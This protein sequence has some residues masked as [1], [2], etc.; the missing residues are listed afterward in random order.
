MFSGAPVSEPS[1]DINGT[2]GGD[3]TGRDKTVIQ[4]AGGD[5]VGRDKITQAAPPIGVAALHQLPAPPS[6][7]VGRKRELRDLAQA[8]QARGLAIS[9]LRGMGRVG[10]TALA[11]KLAERLMPQFPDA[12]FSYDWTAPA[13]RRLTRSKPWRASSALT[14]PRRNC[15]KNWIAGGRSTYRF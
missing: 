2:V 15:R 11:L 7:F 1:I 6:D 8:V 4:R 14:S 9:G 10:K 3:L 12:Q 5:I 13:K